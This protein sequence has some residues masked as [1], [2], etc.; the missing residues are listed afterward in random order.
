VAFALLGYAHFV[1]GFGDNG[2]NGPSALSEAYISS[3][4]CQERGTRPARAL[5]GNVLQPPRT[6]V[7]VYVP[8]LGLDHLAEV[9][10]G[11]DEVSVARVDADVI[12]RP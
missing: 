12:H 6:P 2:A 9:A 8:H 1:P 4:N 3:S 10:G 5:W 11:V 7:T